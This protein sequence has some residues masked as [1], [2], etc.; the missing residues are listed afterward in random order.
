M[1][2]DEQISLIGYGVFKDDAPS[3]SSIS[4]FWANTDFHISSISLHS[5]LWRI[6]VPFSPSRQHL[7]FD[8]SL[9]AIL[10]EFQVLLMCNPVVTKN[11]EDL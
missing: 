2:E 8:Y 4:S 3:G 7:L 1:N 10:I 5:H 6:H 9:I 11:V